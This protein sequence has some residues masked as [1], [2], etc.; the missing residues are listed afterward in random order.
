[1]VK[2]NNILPKLEPQKAISIIVILIITVIGVKLLTSSSA[3]SPYV[4]L[5]AEKGS[6]SVPAAAQSD[7]SSSG[8]SYVNFGG[9][10]PS[11]V[12]GAYSGYQAINAAKSVGDQIGHPLTFITEYLD[13]RDPV[14]SWNANGESIANP[15]YIKQWQ[16]LQTAN[17]TNFR[18]I[19][20]VPMLPYNGPD[21]ITGTSIN[22]LTSASACWAAGAKGD[23]NQY[24][25]TVAQNMVNDGQANSLIRIGWE[26]NIGG[27]PW[28]VHG[29]ATP[30]QYIQ[31]WQNIV[32]TMRSV[33]G[34]KF[35]FVWN[36]NFGG[37]ATDLQNYYPGDSYVDAIGF[38]LYDNGWYT[39]TSNTPQSHWSWFMNAPE[40]LNW[41][42]TFSANHNKQMSF[43]EWGLGW[44][45]C[46][47]GKRIIGLVCPSGTTNNGSITGGDDSYFIQSMATYI[48]THN[49]IEAGIWNWGLA[50]VPNSTISPNATAEFVKDF[51]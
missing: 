2:L 39:N 1:M 31:Y 26:F 16:T 10:I 13:F 24:F 3:Q 25:K 27:F 41:L 36:P 40:G 48:A 44:T 17:N 9:S 8:S 32:T 23:Y 33:P 5:E 20:G 6:L 47:N 43:P 38:D 22:C 29:N 28:A 12:I 7:S 50:P 30:A 42:A 45:D 34:E 19:W 49:F 18:M 14:N 15:Y 21:P 46:S 35:V 4:S 11:K 37:A 51:K